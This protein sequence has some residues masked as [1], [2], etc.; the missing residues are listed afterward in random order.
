MSFFKPQTQEEVGFKGMLGGTPCTVSLELL[1]SVNLEFKRRFL[2]SSFW[3]V[4]GFLSLYNLCPNKVE[5]TI[6][7]TA[8]LQKSLPYVDPE[9]TAIWGWSYGGYLRL[10]SICLYLFFYTVCLLWLKIF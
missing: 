9:R 8:S 10:F 7:V 2:I 6:S 4:R 5:D 3:S 1:R